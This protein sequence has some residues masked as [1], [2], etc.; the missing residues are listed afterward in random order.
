MTITA[1]L[2]T[3]VLAQELI[4]AMDLEFIT[5]PNQQERNRMWQEDLAQLRAEVAQRHGMFWDDTATFIPADVLN[6]PYG[7]LNVWMDIERNEILRNNTL[8]AIDALIYEIPNL[9]DFEIAMGIQRAIS[10]LRDNHFRA[11]PIEV[12]MADL[13]LPLEF[14]H[15]GGSDGGFYLTGTVEAFAHALNHRIVSINGIPMDDVLDKFTGI[16]GTENIYDARQQLQNFLF[17]DFMLHTLGIRENGITTFVL[18]NAYG[19]TT[20]ITLTQEDAISPSDL[21][22]D[23]MRFAGFPS[24][25]V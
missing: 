17:S 5:A 24:A 22:E 25:F 20:E 13:H 6:E 23:A 11:I 15:F 1:L 18:E 19:N 2:G 4:G 8:A 21:G 3:N 9:S 16:M 14:R 12:L 7:R 10:N